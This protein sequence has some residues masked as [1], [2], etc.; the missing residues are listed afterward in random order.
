MKSEISPAAEFCAAIITVS[1]SCA[2]GTRADT[3]GPAL[4]KMLKSAGFRVTAKEIVSD[5]K[6]LISS[7]IISLA[8]SSHLIVTTG[9]TGLS[10]RDVTPEAT[11]EVIEKE[12]PGLAEAMR[13]VSFATTPTAILSRALAGVRRSCLIINLPG[14]EKGSTECLRIILPALPHAL[15]IIR[16]GS[17]ECGRR[18][19]APGGHA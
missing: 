4:E 3:S 15:E 1:D 9:G 2:K 10:E 7:K 5:E 8:E 17:L 14:S 11:R 13:L 19:L 16:H 6:H 18:H 12:V